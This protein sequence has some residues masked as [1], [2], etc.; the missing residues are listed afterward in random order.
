MEP[1]LFILSD[2]QLIVYLFILFETK[3]AG[4]YIAKGIMYVISDLLSVITVA[5][6]LVQKLPQIQ[7]IYTY[8]SAKGELIY[9]PRIESVVLFWVFLSFLLYFYRYQHDFI[10]TRI[11]QL[12][13]DGTLQLHICIFA[14]L[15]LGISHSSGPRICF[16]RPCAQLQTHVESELFCNHWRI[17]GVCTFICIPNLPKISAGHDCGKYTKHCTT[18]YNL[19]FSFY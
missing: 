18:N 19:L 11:V 5:L 2:L 8:K 15:L 14:A 13:G 9:G 1:I 12:H 16:N 7:A 17:L 10:A 4:G 6:C 3:M